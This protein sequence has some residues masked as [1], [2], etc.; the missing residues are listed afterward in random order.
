ME[1]RFYCYGLREWCDGVGIKEWDVF[2]GV[3]RGRFIR[4]KVVFLMDDSIFFLYKYF[5]L[6]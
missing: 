4:E 6:F 5:L 1:L 2:V 3:F